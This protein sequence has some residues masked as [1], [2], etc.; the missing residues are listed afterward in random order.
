MEV[1]PVEQRVTADQRP[2]SDPMRIHAVEAAR[3][4]TEIADLAA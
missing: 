4:R 2:S 1:E 3:L